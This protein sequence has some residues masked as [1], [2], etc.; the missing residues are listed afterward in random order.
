LQATLNRP[1]LPIRNLAFA[2][3][4]NVGQSMLV[5]SIESK[6]DEKKGNRRR[7]LP[8]ETA[9]MGSDKLQVC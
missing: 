5:Q 4:E 2:G 3:N 1:T 8:K 7:A 6:K 9:S